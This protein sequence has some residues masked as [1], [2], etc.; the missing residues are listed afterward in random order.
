M[1]ER[2]CA[3][4]VLGAAEEVDAP[5]EVSIPYLECSLAAVQM[6]HD[7]EETGGLSN[8]LVASSGRGNMVRNA[9]QEMRVGN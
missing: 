6:Q 2:H 4:V 8:I 7:K 3:F 9:C 5:R 1:T